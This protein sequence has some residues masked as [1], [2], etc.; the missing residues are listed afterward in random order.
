[1]N[2]IGLKQPT[3]WNELEKFFAKQ[4]WKNWGTLESFSLG[5]IWKIL[6]GFSI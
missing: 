1:M 4:S 6:Q 5:K 2:N 3:K